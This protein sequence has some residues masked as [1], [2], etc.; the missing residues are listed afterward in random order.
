M[1]RFD[2]AFGIGSNITIFPQKFNTID[3]VTIITGGNTYGAYPPAETVVSIKNGTQTGVV[4]GFSASDNNY[5]N[6]TSD[7]TNLDLNISI[8]LLGYLFTS[9]YFIN[10]INI[11]VESF[12]N[13]TISRLDLEV[14]NYLSNSFDTLGSLN[15]K[16]E[17]NNTFTF[18]QEMPLLSYVDLE[19]IGMKFRIVGEN[20]TF[21]NNYKLSIDML[22]FQ[23]SNASYSI[24][25][26][27]WPQ[28]EVIGIIEDPLLYRTERLNWMAG[29]E[30]GADIAETQNA[31]YI[32]YEKARNQVYIDYKGTRNNGTYDKIT[33]VFIHCK[34]VDDIADTASLL[35]TRLKALGSNWTI[36][37]LKTGSPSIPIDSLAFRLNVFS[38]YIWVEEGEDDEKILEEITEYMEDHGYIILFAF[39]SSYITSI[40]ESMVD[41]ISLI[42]NGILVFA[43][44][45]AMIGLAL[46]CLLTTMAR[47]REIGMLRSIGLNKKGVVRT[48]S[49]ETL[50]VAFL[51]T[52]VGIIA[53]LFTG[54]LMV[55]SIPDTGFLTV[56]LVIPWLIISLLILTTV[57]T[58]IVSSRYPS[59]WAANINI[60]DAVR[61]R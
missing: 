49:G 35:R 14:Y 43:I 24:I 40:F 22:N 39:T 61:T 58:A 25:P 45:I 19:N 18:N 8:D 51:G 12:V 60:I 56:T 41:L 28:Y 16:T 13:S 48:I 36:L 30:V 7:N 3:L 15:S 33:H 2:T 59:K 34:S 57:V 1:R 55:S 47:R 32:N 21:S 46:H 38:W 4:A 42:M 20:S 11:T 37:D 31:V 50:V 10:P 44:I 9:L 23:V 17:K 52:I 27:N 6:F 26:Y 54:F 53:G 29:Y 5:I